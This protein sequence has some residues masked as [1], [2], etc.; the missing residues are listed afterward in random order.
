MR[1]NCSFHK[2]IKYM[3]TFMYNN[4]PLYS[5]NY[6]DLLSQANTWE[7]NGEYIRAIEMLLQLTVNNCDNK[8]LLMETWTK[9][10]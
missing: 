7:E 4:V 5:R 2:E 1:E 9:V 3:Y 8:D 10:I 6:Q